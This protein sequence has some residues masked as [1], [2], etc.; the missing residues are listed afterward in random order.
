VTST[1]NAGLVVAL[2]PKPASAASAIPSLP[3]DHPARSIQLVKVWDKYKAIR[4]S[5]YNPKTIARDVL[6]A[7]GRHPDIRQLNAHLEILKTAFPAIDNY[8]DLSTVRWDVIDPGGVEPGSAVNVARTSIHDAVIVDDADDED[9]E[10][11]DI[12]DEGRDALRQVGR[13]EGMVALQSRFAVS[14]PSTLKRKRL[15]APT[16]AGAGIRT[17]NPGTGAGGVSSTGAAPTPE[18]STASAGYTALRAAQTGSGSE[19]LKKRGRPVGWRKWMMKGYTGPPATVAAPEA[20]DDALP[21]YR[22]YKCEWQDCDTELHNLATL[23]K[24]IFKLHS[25][26]SADGQLACLWRH[27]GRTKTST[28]ADGR[29]TTSLKLVRRTFDADAAWRAHVEATHL[30]PIAWKLGDGPAGGLSDFDGSSAAASDAYLSD[31]RGRRVTP[32]IVISDERAL[33]AADPS[34]ARDLSHKP[35]TPSREQVERNVRAT[36]VRRRRAIGPG[37]DRGGARLA[38]DKRRMGLVDDDDDAMQI[39]DD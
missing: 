1:S 35:A 9:D 12:L 33:R 4:R 14:V 25:K 23:R 34:V 16:S 22:V 13:P 11:D 20:E 15:L 10:L 36:E 7:C 28:S 5:A 30:K 37:I 21:D 31:A 17:H 38:N 6:L 29:C 2:P 32:Q 24:H 18:Q 27:C 39:V 19:P 26:R 3:A 8:A